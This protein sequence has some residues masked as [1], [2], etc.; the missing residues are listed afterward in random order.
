[1]QSKA[2]SIESRKRKRKKKC[3]LFF[4][5]GSAWGYNSHALLSLCVACCKGTISRSRTL[6]SPGRVALFFSR[7]GSRGERNR[8]DGDGQNGEST[9]YGGR[10]DCARKPSVESPSRQVPS[11]RHR[12]DR[13]GPSAR[14]T[15]QTSPQRYPSVQNF[16]FVRGRE[17]E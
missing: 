16:P 15:R 13:I 11:G 12:S 10:S 1:M 8:V 2:P 3:L 4:S 14:H 6:A 17:T 5:F 7:H 9:H